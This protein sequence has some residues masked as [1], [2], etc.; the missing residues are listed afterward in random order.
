MDIPTVESIRNEIKNNS[1]LFEILDAREKRRSK[2]SIDKKV[3]YEN[4]LNKLKKAHDNYMNKL[5]N[6]IITKTK[7]VLKGDIN[8]DAFTL[9]QPQFIDCDLGDFSA[10]TIYRGIWDKKRKK[11]DRIPHIEAGIKNDPIK[12]INERMKNYG[13]K[14]I[15]ISK[16]TGKTTIKIELK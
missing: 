16:K 12:E 6:E 11:Y 5:Q 7:I 14:I 8:T 15:D 4:F 2:W 1:K 10:N 3:E 9:I 13:Y